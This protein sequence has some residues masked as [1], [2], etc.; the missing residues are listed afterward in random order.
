MLSLFIK[1]QDR[2]SHS[3]V[4][5]TL[6]LFLTMASV[7]FL[8]TMT[9]IGFHGAKNLS[10]QWR[11]DAIEFVT[12]QIPDP[13]TPI[14]NPISSP[15]SNS[16]SAQNTPTNTPNAA[17]QRVNFVLNTL[18]TS[19]PTNTSIHVLQTDQVRQ[20]LTP[21]LGTIDT[22]SLPLPAVI[23]IRL[24]PRNT[25]PSSLEQ[26]L[27]QQIP[28][29]V[30]ERNF[31]WNY[32]LQDL[33]TYLL[34]CSQL[35]FFIV[36]VAS[37]VIMLLCAHSTLTTCRE[38]MVLLHNLGASDAYVAGYFAHRTA[39]LIVCGSLVGVFIA[40]LLR[41]FLYLI[42]PFHQLFDTPPLS[43]DDGSYFSL[44]SDI[45]PTPLLLELLSLLILTYVFCWLITHFF[46]R[47]WLH[48]L[49]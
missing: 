38:T 3:A 30:I 46:V 35:V 33:S 42:T 27:Q 15:I 32:Y 24:P 11:A 36:E 40:C 41:F 21:W 9:L 29:L 31:R 1:Y 6:T 45:F 22:N 34:S 49:P 48:H 14:A 39:C 19:L 16:L 47:S 25:M 17:Q 18:K 2:P 37:V 20:L 28:D 26:T 4:F 23:E 13:T 10:D 43:S 12:L 8:L 44:V 5:P 7:M